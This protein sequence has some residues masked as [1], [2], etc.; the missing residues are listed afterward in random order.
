MNHK[1]GATGCQ[2]A[3]NARAY[4]IG[5]QQIN[6]FHVRRVVWG[7]LMARL[8]K[9]PGEVIKRAVILVEKE[10]GKVKWTTPKPSIA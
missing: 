9:R 5:T 3:A 8:E 6:G 2:H 4:A 1:I 7:S 10:S